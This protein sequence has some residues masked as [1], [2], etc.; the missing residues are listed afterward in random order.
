M[1]VTSL[2]RRWVPA[3]R[4]RAYTLLY[5]SVLIAT[6]SE[7][8]ETYLQMF[9]V[10]AGWYH[11]MEMV[12]G[13]LYFV[14]HLTSGFFYLIYIFSVLD[15]YVDLQSS[16]D[17]SRVALPS[18]IGILLVIINIF[19]PILFYYSEDGR[20]HR[21]NFIVLFYLLAIYYLAFGAV[22]LYKFMH[23]MRRRTRSVVTAFVCLVVSGMIIQFFVPTVLI[24]NF[25][26]T[27][28][29]T[30][31]YITLQ[32]PSEM[33][34]ENLNILNRKA[35]LEGLD[36]KTNRNSPHGT[37]FVSI[38][39]MKALSDEI[40]YN[41][42]QGVL[43]RIT[44]YLKKV[45]RYDFRLQTYTYRYSE[46]VF[47]ITVHCEDDR[48]IEALL[49]AIS[50]R[51]TEPWTAANMTIRAEGHC[52][53]IKYP[54]HYS[55]TSE[56]MSKLD[57][58]MNA[59]TEDTEPIIDVDK[60]NITEMRRELDYDLMARRNLDTKS[61]IIRFQPM[62]SKIYKMNYICDVMVFLT[63][64]YGNEIDMRGHIP[65]PGSTQSLMDTDEYVYRRACRALTFWNDGDKNG[66]YRAVV[67]L[68]QGE[69]SRTDFI[70]R[71]KKILREERTEPGWISIKLTETTITTMN[72]IAER[73]LKMLADMKVSIIVDKFG[74]GYGNISKILELPVTQVNINHE[75]LEKATIS[76]GMMDVAK[77]IVNLFHDISIFVGASD[78]ENE[79][80][81]LIAEELGCDY[82][83]GDFIGRPMKDS[84]FTKIIDAY[85]D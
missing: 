18:C 81:K 46:N 62:V 51:L 16:H 19:T 31:V 80:D 32:N 67:G 82:L 36:L 7:R 14:A 6:L 66:K 27:I 34:D 44:K 43:K 60:L 41:Q 72:A 55:D 15:I 30:L 83:I 50:K 20:Y 56:L 4:Q 45:G 57:I 10:D 23:I 40:G 78:I 59:V 48:R 22:S 42:T 52:F 69:I 25:F 39:N 3:Y 5:F 54:E 76:G 79:Q 53:L 38:D 29:I 33:V 21:G 84:S 70:R 65:D 71:I 64:E 2:S 12:T 49:Y 47:A 8:V 11:P 28:S 85:Y 77:G 9:P 68:S 26:M 75:I 1:A 61:S 58:I 17:F 35:F 73:N 74:S 24:E 13:S 37:I 63:D